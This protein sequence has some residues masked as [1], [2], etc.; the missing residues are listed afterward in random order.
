MN[1]VQIGNFDLTL[2]AVPMMIVTINTTKTS[3]EKS[4]A[5]PLKYM[6]AK[7]TENP[8]TLFMNTPSYICIS[9]TNKTCTLKSTIKEQ[10]PNM[11]HQY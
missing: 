2:A 11:H 3:A 9:L 1:D 4:H 8:R 10:Q 7:R 5:R 6:T